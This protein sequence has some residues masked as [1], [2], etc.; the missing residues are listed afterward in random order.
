MTGSTVSVVAHP[1]ATTPRPI[2]PRHPATIGAPLGTPLVL[3]LVEKGMSSGLASVIV[4]VP[5]SGGNALA[6]E[7]SLRALSKALQVMEHKA[8]EWRT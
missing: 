2:K 6:V 4:E 3:H 1:I 5:T 8:E 7:V